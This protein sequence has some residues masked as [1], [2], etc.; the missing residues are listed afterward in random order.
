[1]GAPSR[2]GSDARRTG[3]FDQEPHGVRVTHRILIPL[4]QVRILVRLPFPLI[5]DATPILFVREGWQLLPKSAP[6]SVSGCERAVS[7]CGPSRHSRSRA[8]CS[9]PRAK[10]GCLAQGSPG[11]FAY[12]RG[13][14]RLHAQLVHVS[15]QRRSENV[16]R[17]HEG[18]ADPLRAGSKV[19][20][21]VAVAP[22]NG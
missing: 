5:R 13:L 10:R 9:S 22:Q 3:G 4:F 16:Q 8:F 7:P 17:Q 21:R 14:E 12:R 20:V 2:P 6:K 1:M 18:R 15:L 11:M 19:F